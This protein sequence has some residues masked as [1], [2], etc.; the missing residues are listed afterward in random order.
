[1]STTHQ[2]PS[3]TPVSTSKSAAAAIAKVFR[4]GNSQAIRIPHAFKTDVAE[5]TICRFGEDGFCL[6]PAKD[7]WY[8]LRQCLKQLKNEPDI[9]RN[10]PLL[11]DLPEREEL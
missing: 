10:Q 11:S 3:P 7:Q 1:M 4:S 9:K 6:Y 8:L 5:F 2:K